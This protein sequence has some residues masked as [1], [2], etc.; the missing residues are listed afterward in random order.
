MAQSTNSKAA[1]LRP[2]R[3]KYWNLSKLR[4]NKV[5]RIMKARGISEDAATEYWFS[6]KTQA[7]TTGSMRTS[8]EHRGAGRGR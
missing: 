8:L 4:K 2:A 5:A 7:R 6:V 1:D 3:T